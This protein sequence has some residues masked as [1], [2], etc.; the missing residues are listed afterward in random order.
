MSMSDGLFGSGKDSRG[1]ALDA[2]DVYV[3][4]NVR[5]RVED[6]REAICCALKEALEERAEAGDVQTCAMVALVASGVLRIGTHRVL[7]FVEAYIEL[8]TRM[9]LY[10]TAAYLRKHSALTD[11]RSATNL[12]T[13]VY[14]SCGTCGKPILAQQGGSMCATCRSPAAQCS[15]CHLPVKSM[16]FQCAVCSHG[17]HQACYRRFYAEI[18]LALLSAPQA[19]SPGSPLKL[20]PRLYRSASTSRSKDRERD[21][22]TDIV[23]PDD[24]FDTSTV[25]P[26]PRQ[27]MGHP[28]AAGCGHFC[29][30][31]RIHAMGVL[32]RITDGNWPG[33]S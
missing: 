33:T 3:R 23:A 11:I 6:V 27:L 32:M 31:Y 16:L 18:P 13:T 22:A 19:P 21:D 4:N 7:L 20:P 29:W 14:I 24:L 1:D 10:I 9:K 5:R 8:L 15:I 25:T 28:C 17:G 2:Q 12:Q 30:R 26:A